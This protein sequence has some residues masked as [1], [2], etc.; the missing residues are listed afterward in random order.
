M[1]FTAG[2]K[3]YAS[4][5]LDRLDPY[6]FISHRLYRDSRK[7]V[8]G[9]YHVKDLSNLGR[10]LRNVLIVDDKHRSY[11]L[12]PENG[13]PIKR[14]IDDLHDDELK[15]L[16]DN[17]FKSCDKY[18]DLKD[19]LK[20]YRD[21]NLKLRFKLIGNN[22]G[23]D[24]V[25]DNNG[26][27]TCTRVFTSGDPF[28]EAKHD[29]YEVFAQI[30]MIQTLIE[31]RELA[32]GTSVNGADVVKVVTDI[33]YIN[34]VAYV[35]HVL[36]HSRLHKELTYHS[37]KLHKELGVLADLESRLTKM[38]SNSVNKGQLQEFNQKV[39]WRHEDISVLRE[40]SPW[41]RSYDYQTCHKHG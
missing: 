25:I 7:L 39:M 2:T 22:S 34:D 41:V 27:R 5:V 13:I 40:M 9:K 24:E 29:M 15:K 18:E 16:M 26:L 32:S 6:G 35:V 33:A 21:F 19:A 20:H 4:P 8:N 37:K 3:E 1:I 28:Y 36:T 23:Q 30:T 10:D 12:Q 17:F 38:Q 31:V 14:F 11:K